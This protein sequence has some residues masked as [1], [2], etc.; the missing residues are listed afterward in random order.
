MAGG[1]LGQLNI[2]MSADVG[3]AISDIGKAATQINRQMQ[4]IQLGVS[5]LSSAF[6]VLGSGAGIG[7]FI[8]GAIDTGDR[9]NDLRTRTGLLGQELL[10]LEGAAVR[11]GTSLEA[12][13]D[14]T[15]KLGKRLGAVEIGTGEAANAFA[16]MGIS[17]T[18][19]GG[20]MK[21]IGEIL[22]E[23]GEKFKGYEDGAAKATLATA[24]FGKGGDKLIPVIEGITD[25][26]SRFKRLG[27]TINEDF[28]TN[29][30]K[31]KDT[32]DDIKSLNDVLA[33]QI[34][35]AL[36]PYMQQLADVM[37]TLASDT[38]T[39]GAKVQ[40]IIVPLKTM[41]TGV[42]VVAQGFTAATEEA[43]G[44]GL[45]LDRLRHFDIAGAAEEMSKG[46]ARAAARDAQTMK[47]IAALWGTAP[48]TQIL[49]DVDNFDLMGKKKAPKLAN[50]KA[51]EAAAKAE[52][53]MRKRMRELDNSGWV[54][55]IDTMIQEYED[56]LREMAKIDDAARAI[57][58]RGR[59]E[60]MQA[61]FKIID[62]QEAAAIEVG[63]A[64]LA[65]SKKT[66][67]EMTEFWKQAAR[68]ME[69]AMSGF[70]FDVMQ[71]NLSNLGASFKRTIDQMVAN[72]L[73][74]KAA[75][76]LFGKG[77]GGE[78]VALGGLVGKAAGFISDIFGGG[79]TGANGADL[80]MA[81]GGPVSGG[82]T[83]LVGERGPELFTPASSGMITPNHALGGVNISMVINTPNADSFRASRGQII[84]DMS[85]AMAGARR[86]L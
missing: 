67:D 36:L 80:A 64:I 7:A 46:M 48:P 12:I 69:T 31:F 39:M 44:F 50:L 6:L 19:A 15:S 21:T 47:V 60:G 49:S 68:N 72:I 62:D 65:A 40:A 78:G 61:Y 29:A 74:A 83:Y 28:L 45:A 70:F 79:F 66:T 41:A 59:A 77:F 63:E 5:R 13:S 56:G 71:G 51:Q 24:A 34:A 17:V 81:G 85:V 27:I 76:A 86:N 58:E 42:Y 14:V 37:V 38:E 23:A 52:A 1:A 8:K 11:G 57:S 22:R 3:Q 9:M 35:T 10:T 26:D 33:R 16:A 54:K 20:G 73:A 32:M 55:H 30:D 53:D 2:K 43:V 82:S 75:T 18:R 25:V 4:S 84:A